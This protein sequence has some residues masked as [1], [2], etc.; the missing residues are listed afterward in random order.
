MIVTPTEGTAL[1]D[2]IAPAERQDM[3]SGDSS[4]SPASTDATTQQA[5][6]VEGRIKWFD[7]TRGFG[8]IIPD[9]AS[10]GDVL[11]HFTILRDHGRRMLPEGTTI[12]CEAIEGRRGLQASKVLHFDLSTA[13][14]LDLE[15][16]SNKR[17]TRTNPSDLLD[18]AKDFEPVEVKWFNRFKGYG[19][20]V[21]PGQTE[22][23]FVHMETLRRGNVIEAMPEDKLEAR[24]AP[25]SKGLIAVEVR[26]T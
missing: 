5:I 18:D 8:F 21:R 22:D 24:I 6:L 4:F 16:Q 7:A 9:V 26:R 20:L 14:G 13:T 12:C 11:I 10:M 25:T 3:P 23:I 1:S 17:P 2:S 19:F 15:V